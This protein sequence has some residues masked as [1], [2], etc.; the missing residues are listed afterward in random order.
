MITVTA[1]ELYSSSSD[2]EL[3]IPEEAPVPVRDDQ[4][5]IDVL[6]KA[7][8]VAAERIRKLE[9]QNLELRQKNTEL[10][11]RLKELESDEQQGPRSI[12]RSRKRNVPGDATPLEVR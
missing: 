3:E 9:K 7:I 1:D 4:P 8:V 12:A 10:R 11:R 5:K 2:G 6:R